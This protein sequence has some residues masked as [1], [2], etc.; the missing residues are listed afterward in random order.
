MDKIIARLQLLPLVLVEALHNAALPGLD[1]AHVR[2]A[3]D[4]GSG[5]GRRGASVVGTRQLKLW[6]QMG[7]LEKSKLLNFLELNRGPDYQP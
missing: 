2:R 7:I 3:V 4:V 6:L 1:M 5:S